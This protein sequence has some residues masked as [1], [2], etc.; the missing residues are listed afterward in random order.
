MSNTQTSQ[1]SGVAL[2]NCGPRRLPVYFVVDFSVSAPTGFAADALRQVQT[3]LTK[4]RTQAEQ[5]REEYDRAPIFYTV[6]VFRNTALQVQPLAS[7][8]AY[9]FGDLRLEEIQPDGSSGLGPALAALGQSFDLELKMPGAD[10]GDFTPLVFLFTD[11]LLTD[12]KAHRQVLSNAR[13]FICG[14]QAP[15][16]GNSEFSLQARPFISDFLP[17]DCHARIHG[18]IEQA[19]TQLRS[20]QQMIDYPTSY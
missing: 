18:Q 11:S 9:S 6:I 7:L 4:L 2:E 1:S 17:L 8:W 14:A 12:W 3:V 16:P 19:R 5:D 15:A 10:N 20:R 13:T